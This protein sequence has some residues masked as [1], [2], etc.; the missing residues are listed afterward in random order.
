MVMASNSLRR[1]VLVTL[2]LGVLLPRDATADTKRQRRVAAQAAL[3]K[4]SALMF[5]G[6]RISEALAAYREAASLVPDNLT[7]SENIVK[8]LFGHAHERRRRVWLRWHSDDEE[9]LATW[10]RGRDAEAAAAVRHHVALVRTQ[11]GG[12]RRSVR[13]HRRTQASSVPGTPL[14]TQRLRQAKQAAQNANWLGDFAPSW[15]GRLARQYFAARTIFF[16]QRTRN[17]AMVGG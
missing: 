6:A 4:A 16:Y 11:T 8:L 13:A 3:Q 5:Q 7:P 9:I 17:T 14:H 2:L 12:L 1:M 10:S 15:A